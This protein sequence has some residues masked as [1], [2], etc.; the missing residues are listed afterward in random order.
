MEDREVKENIIYEPFTNLNEQE[1]FEKHLKN[2]IEK[3]LENDSIDISKDEEELITENNKFLKNIDVRS[4][5]LLT[6]FN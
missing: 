4:K 2:D 1:L 6:K 3:N 5:E